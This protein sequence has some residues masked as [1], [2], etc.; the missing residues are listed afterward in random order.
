MIFCRGTRGYFPYERQ[1]RA[2]FLFEGR[3]GANSYIGDGPN[4]LVRA[5]AEQA[6]VKMPSFGGYMLWSGAVLI[7]VFILITFIF[8]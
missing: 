6:R 1:P 8:F 5:I 4:F 7:P 3:K 2:A